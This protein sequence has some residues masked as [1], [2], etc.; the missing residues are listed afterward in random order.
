M[1]SSRHFGITFFTT[2]II[3]I[4]LFSSI[5]TLAKVVF[6]IGAFLVARATVSMWGNDVGVGS[7]L[8]SFHEDR[9]SWILLT[10]EGSLIL[11][12]AFFR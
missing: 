5:D 4:V 8:P 7:I 3:L 6:S 11:Y 9:L 2:I 10:I 12:I 1:R